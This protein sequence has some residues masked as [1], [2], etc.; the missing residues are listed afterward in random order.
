MLRSFRFANHKSFADEQELLL[1]PATGDAVNAALPVAAVYGANASGKSNLLDALSFM[2]STVTGSSSSRRRDS[3]PLRMPFRLDSARGS[4]PSLFVVEFIA[5]EIRYTYGF[6]IS[7]ERVLEEWLYS[8][9]AKRKRVLFEREDDRFSIGSTL[10]E[11]KSEL[12]V[13]QRL[14]RPDTLF[15][16][17][18]LEA[19]FSGPIGDHFL[20]IYWWFYAI[21]NTPDHDGTRVVEAD[22]IER[23]LAEDSPSRARVLELIRAA[24]V[25]ISDVRVDVERP[26]D[27]SDYE[28]RRLVFRHGRSRTEFRASDESSGTRSWLRI[29]PGALAA[30]AKGY[31]LVI[32]E[33]DTSLHPLLTAELAALFQ[34]PATNPLGAQ[35]LFTSHDPSLLGTAVRPGGLLRRDQIWFVDKDADGASTLYPLTDFKPR[36]EHNLERRYLNGAYGAIPSLDPVRFANAIRSA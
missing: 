35:L 11:I 33:I 1:I 2:G 19:N 7:D 13:L 5:D 10:A 28:V 15:L 24:D 12:V 23:L 32:D 26:D 31:V 14:T 36:R 8:Y 27:Y 29:L 25:G 30:L 17:R 20:S 21:L 16:T 22:G 34:D 9:P 4:A 3:D 6:S 18:I